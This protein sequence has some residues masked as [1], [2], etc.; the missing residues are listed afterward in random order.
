MDMTRFEGAYRGTP[1]WVI[2]RHQPVFEALAEAGDIGGAVL[3]AGCSA[4]ENAVSLASCGLEGA[5][6]ERPPAA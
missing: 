1:P 2:G 4:G 5:R 3:D 6:A